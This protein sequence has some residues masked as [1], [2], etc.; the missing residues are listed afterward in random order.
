MTEH[1]PSKRRSILI[2]LGVIVFVVLVALV[3]SQ[4][5]ER[6]WLLSE[7]AAA[8]VEALRA[9]GRP[10][11]VFFHSPDCRS[12]EVVQQSL[13]QVYAEFEKTIELLDVD[14]TNQRERTFIDESGVKTAPTLLLIDRSG[15]EKLVAGEI[16]A[17]EMYLLLSA[18]SG[19]AP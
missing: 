2:S 19:G 15:A 10:V 6:R 16:N 4:A 13:D 11:V 12:C 14:V 8:R 9:E 5:A 18:L 7:P 3:K 1:L 17:E